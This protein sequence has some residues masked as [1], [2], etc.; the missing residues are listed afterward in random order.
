MQ[1]AR[2]NDRMRGDFHFPANA[3]R[4]ILLLLPPSSVLPTIHLFL[5]SIPLFCFICDMFLALSERERRAIGLGGL[6]L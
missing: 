2:I 6:G 5:L 1:C 4:I 3:F